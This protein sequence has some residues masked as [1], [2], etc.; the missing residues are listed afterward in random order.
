MYCEDGY[1]K[2][3]INVQTGISRPTI[4]RVLSGLDRNKKYY[5]NR[6]VD[7][8]AIDLYKH[9]YSI[10]A[11]AKAVKKT[12]NKIVKLLRLHGV[13]PMSGRRMKV[14]C[15]VSGENRIRLTYQDF[16]Y[17]MAKQNYRCKI[18]GKSFGYF[19]PRV[20]HKK[21]SKIIRGIL[22]NSCNVRLSGVEDPVFLE[23][24]LEYLNKTRDNFTA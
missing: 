24:A 7:E 11:T 4:D 22:C 1:S 15:I 14:V 20:D 10:S 23:K 17:L 3:I 6:E 12:S 21:G 9:N 8:K 16:E 18:C 5:I 13:I 2:S 19:K